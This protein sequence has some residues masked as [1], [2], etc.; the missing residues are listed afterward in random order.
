MRVWFMV[1]IVAFLAFEYRAASY[2]ARYRAC[3]FILPKQCVEDYT[4]QDLVSVC[5]FAALLF[6]FL[7]IDFDIFDLTTM[8]VLCAY[9]L[10]MLGANYHL[11]IVSNRLESLCLA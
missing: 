4:N 6:A 9:V 11:I 10:M 5:T 2:R 7:A 8:G 1:Y 3:R